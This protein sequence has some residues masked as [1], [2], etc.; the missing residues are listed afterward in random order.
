MRSLGILGGTF[1]PIHY[2]HLQLARTAIAQGHVNRVLLM[3]SGRPP[4]KTAAAPAQDR[5]AMTMLAAFGMEGVEVSPLESSALSVSYTADTFARLN[6]ANP[7]TELYLILG[8][9]AAASLPRWKNLEALKARCAGVLL[10]PRSGGPGG[11]SLADLAGMPVMRLKMDMLPITSSQ[12]RERAA[13]QMDASDLTPAA[14]YIRQH[15]LYGSTQCEIAGRLRAS[16]S[17]SRFQHT[18]SVATTA[19]CLAYVHGAD[20]RKAHLAG[21]LHDCAK[22]Y[23]LEA[24]IQ[25]IERGN[26]EVDPEERDIPSICHAPAGVAVARELYGVSDPEVLSAIRWHTT[27][28]RGM[29]KLDKVVYLADMIEPM[30]RPFPGLSRIR[31]TAYRNLDEAA[32]LA[33]RTSADHILGGGRKLLR[34][35]LEMLEGDPPAENPKS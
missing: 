17:L 32:L 16:M 22:G 1:D 14:D 27:G 4:H 31:Q 24:Q 30:R 12:V 19:V 34:R 7:D 28:R 9:D 18:L 11:E 35:T 20:P 3:P 10:A 29:T 6:D 21:L 2:G 5:L 25:W 15:G 33:A 26:V 13:L 8:Q 23:R